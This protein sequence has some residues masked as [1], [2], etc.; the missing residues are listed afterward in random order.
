MQ[1]L[2]RNK[3]LQQYNNYKNSRYYNLYDLYKSYSYNKQRAFDYC[4]RLCYDYK[5][6]DLKIIGGNTCTFSAG[7]TY[8]NDNGEL[9]FVWITKDYDRECVIDD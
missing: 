2:K 8:I 6:T 5:G 4:K 7:F 1:T 3:L 9:V